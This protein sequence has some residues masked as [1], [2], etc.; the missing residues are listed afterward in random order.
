GWV[1]KFTKDFVNSDALA[2]KKEAGP[3]RRLIAFQMEERGIPRTGYPI[4]DS[5]GK[6]IGKV[7]S[8]TMAPSLSQGIGLG[9]VT[10]ENAALDTTIFIQIRINKVPAKVVKLPFY[11]PAR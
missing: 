10:P 6:E 2:K 7:T 8:E 3:Q 5:A 1:T 11:K 4:L 9:Y